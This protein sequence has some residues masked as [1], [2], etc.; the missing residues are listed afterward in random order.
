VKVEQGLMLLDV[1]AGRHRPLALGAPAAGTSLVALAYGSGGSAR[2]LVAVAGEHDAGR[3][4]APLQP[5]GA[6]APVFDRVG[7]L[8]GLVKAVPAVPRL[9][10]GVAL[11]AGHALVT[12]EALA[13]L[14]RE[15]GAP[16]PL[17]PEPVS[18]LSAGEIAAAVGAAVV[19]VDC[20]R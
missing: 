18:G 12:G 19:P 8:V 3:L 9:V 11:P 20:G 17:N 2:G 13:A 4:M 1:E 10:A 14:L 5:G 15:A 7:R 6:G 16:A